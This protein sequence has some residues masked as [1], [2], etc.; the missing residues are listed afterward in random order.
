MN[1]QRLRLFLAVLMAGGGGWLLFADIAPVA[2]TW[3]T[4]SEVGTAG[5]N[6]YRAVSTEA[7]FEQVNV[8]L[9]PAQ[10][11]ELTGA[12]YRFIDDA[13]RVGQQYFY[14]IEEV[15]WDGTVTSYPEIVQVRAGLPRLWTKLEGGLLIVLAGIILWR[16]LRR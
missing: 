4:A 15:E 3:E 8:A 12:T 13:V 14:R 6:V 2:L 7:V 11:D 1:V 10:G 16:E 9:I 5:F